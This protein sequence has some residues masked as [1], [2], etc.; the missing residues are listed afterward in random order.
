MYQA[1]ILRSTASITLCATLLVTF[2]T[3][4]NVSPCCIL[5]GKEIHFNL[6]KL[7][8]ISFP[9]SMQHGE[10]F[11]QVTKVTSNVAQSVIEAVERRIA[12]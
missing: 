3:C 7:K 4:A 11:A 5:L 2:V 6:A 1:A 8:C 9:S 12:A 10:T